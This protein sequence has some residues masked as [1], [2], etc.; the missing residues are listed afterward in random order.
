MIFA[1]NPGIGAQA[2]EDLLYANCDDIGAAGEDSTFGHG[3]VNLRK[4][5]EAGSGGGP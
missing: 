5:V 3:R 4:A 1:N 2:A